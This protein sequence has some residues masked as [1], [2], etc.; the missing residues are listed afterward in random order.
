MFQN[1][2]DMDNGCEE[3]EDVSSNIKYRLK[4]KKKTTPIKCVVN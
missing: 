1:V 2:A 4:K 3:T